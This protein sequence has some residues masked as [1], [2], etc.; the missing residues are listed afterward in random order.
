[1][2]WVR[3]DMPIHTKQ[4]FECAKKCYRQ[5]N[6]TNADIYNY[7]LLGKYGLPQR[8]MRGLERWEMQI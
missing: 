1:M 6:W 4:Q 5:R 7:E 2:R 8:G 3:N